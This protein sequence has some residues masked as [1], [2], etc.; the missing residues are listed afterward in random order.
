MLQRLAR[1]YIASIVVIAGAY[2]LVGRLANI[3]LP[4][5]LSLAINIGFVSAMMLLAVND[6]RQNYRA[7]Q[8][9]EDRFR[10]VF[11]RSAIGIALVNRQGYPVSVNPALE[12]MLGY[13]SAE[14]RR[15]SIAD[16]THPDDINKNAHLFDQLIRGEIDSYS[17]E[18][19]YIHKNGAVVWA[20]L[21]VSIFPH[22]SRDE[23]YM[24]SMVEDITERKQAEAALQQM[25]AELEKRVAERTAEI[26]AANTRLIEL[27]RQKSEFVAYISHELRTPL[28]VLN[29]RVYLLEHSPAERHAEYLAGLK[30]EIE[31]LTILANN[32][33]D[34]SRLELSRDDATFVYVD[35]NKAAERAVTA[36]A[37]RAEAK[38]LGLSFAPGHNLPLVLGNSIRLTQ[39]A[40]NLVSNA[41][42]YTPSGS[43]TVTTGYDSANHR[44][45]LSVQDT[46]IGISPKE[47]E[48]L[49]NRFFRSD[50]AEALGVQGS[51]LGLRI[52]HQII[53]QHGGSIEVVSDVNQGTRFVVWLPGIKSEKTFGD[54]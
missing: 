44:V 45:F 17:M 40:T 34:L 13:S 50:R 43:V 42:N 8:H 48:Y 6:H 38:G 19:R 46:G 53:E 28:T 3:L 11:E 25:N 51:G 27:D 41:I 39:V 9:G 10:T 21:N 29:T 2:F 49:F 52:V 20:R 7:R 12:R 5:F 47:Q 16:F 22:D 30:T 32:V 1:P 15:M 18:K 24:I 36:L 26:E 23:A 4:N 54:G 31:N 14:I 35:F 37:P 33:L